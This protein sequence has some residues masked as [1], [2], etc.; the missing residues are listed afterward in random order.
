MYNLR[1]ADGIQGPPKPA[2]AETQAEATR[3]AQRAGTAHANPNEPTSDRGRKPSFD[4]AQLGIIREMLARD[5]SPAE[6][7]VAAGVTQQVVYGVQDG[8]A[9]GTRC[10]PSGGM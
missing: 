1:R 8:P 3:E 10:W 6:I 9:K 5:A 4:R 2:T 7:A